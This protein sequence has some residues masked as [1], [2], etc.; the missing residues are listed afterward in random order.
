M[1]KKRAVIKYFELLGF[2]F[3]KGTNHDMLIHPDGRR[4]VCGRHTEISNQMFEK[5]K[6]E[7]GIRKSKR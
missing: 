3:K 2:K 1:V 7:A 5:M 4:T 6:K